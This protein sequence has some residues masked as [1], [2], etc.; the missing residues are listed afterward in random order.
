MMTF[1]YLVSAYQLLDLSFHVDE[2]S[3]VNQCFI[4]ALKD[5]SMSFSSSLDWLPSLL[6][7]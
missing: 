2:A 7:L 5:C 6:S 1:I 4:A 3:T